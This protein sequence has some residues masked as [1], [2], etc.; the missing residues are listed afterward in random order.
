[1][2]IKP[3]PEKVET[4]IYNLLLMRKK[5]H[6]CLEEQWITYLNRVKEVE[7]MGIT[8]PEYM[9]DKPWIRRSCAGRVK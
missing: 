5:P 2:R 3:L 6:G 9:V 1:M 7:S 8:N 4:P